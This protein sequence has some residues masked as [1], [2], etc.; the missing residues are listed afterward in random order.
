[1]KTHARSGPRAPR[2]ARTCRLG[3][4]S[5]ALTVGL[6]LLAGCGG[7]KKE[8]ESKPNVSGKV[9]RGEKPVAGTVFFITADNK[10]FS[11]NIGPDGSYALADAPVGSVKIYIKPGQALV[12]PKGGP[13]MPKDGPTATQGVPPPPKYQSPATSGLTY[14]VKAGKQTYDI[15]LK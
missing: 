6:S 13:E 4:W 9:T 3:L 15:P 5:V 11:A 14:D 12:A 1:M 8:D 10:E 2:L 7:G